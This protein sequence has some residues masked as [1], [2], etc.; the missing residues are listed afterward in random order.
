MDQTW[1]MTLGDRMRAIRKQLDLTQADI[2]AMLECTRGAV[3]QF[4]TGN[5]QPGIETL[6]TFARATGASLDWLLLGK[7][8]GGQYDP[9]IQALPDALRQYVIEAL[10]LA[11]RVQLSIPDGLL[12]PPTTANYA[13]FSDYLLRLSKADHPLKV[14]KSSVLA[15]SR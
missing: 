1:W 15:G 11:E 5:N 4:E 7:T 2:S 3:S 10:L 9:R 13:Q 14:G 8:P 6:V 12:A